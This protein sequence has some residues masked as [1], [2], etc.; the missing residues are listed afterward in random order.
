MATLSDVAAAARVSKA[1][2]SRA[3]SRPEL[4]APD[5]VARVRA[6]AEELE[7]VANRAAR[8][9][10]R[11]RTG[12]LGLLVPT[13][14]NAFFAPIIGGAQV[15]AEEEDLQLSV[16]V[17]PLEDPAELTRF[18]RLAIGVDGFLVVAPRGPDP[19]LLA[20]AARKPVVLVD[21]EVD[22][23]ASVV[24]DTAA[25]FAEL[26]R[27]LAEAGHRR[28]LYIGGPDRSWQ[29]LQRT[30]SL[31][32]AATAV[33]VHLEVLGPCPATFDAGAGLVD[34][35]A[36]SDADAVLPYASDLGLGLMLGLIGRGLARVDGGS[37]ADATGRLISVVGVPGTPRVDVDGERLGAAAIDQL[38][39]TLAGDGEPV[40]SRLHVPI[41]WAGRTAPTAR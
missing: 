6:A 13:F 14:S 39:A 32:T 27:G 34:R 36:A 28:I 33:G 11:G 23:L 17:H 16:A 3:L 40:R 10:A 15:R 5:T 29:N 12:I 1:T 21:R 8:H 26:L 25:A 7:F 9:L 2:A 41:S 22:G 37:P 30:G 19:L 4:V 20:A 31:H 18:D 24:A 38:V 35:V